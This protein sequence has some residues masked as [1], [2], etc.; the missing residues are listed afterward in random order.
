[1]EKCTYC[2]QRVNAARVETKIA[3]LEIIPDGFSRWPASRRARPRDRVRRHL[4]LYGLPPEDGTTREGSRVSLAR[5]SQRSY[6][7]LAYLNTRP[8]TT[9]QIRVHNPNPA[10]IEELAAS[11]DS[12]A[13]DRLHRWEEPFHHGEDH[14]ADHS[15]DHSND[16]GE[17]HAAAKRF[18]LPILD[19]NGE[20]A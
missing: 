5:N 6:A 7:L 9:Y 8:R 4:R 2:I 18:A 15:D 20:I 14:S 19:A 16:H 13:T 1:M 10:W 3:D 12:A 17:E 11:G